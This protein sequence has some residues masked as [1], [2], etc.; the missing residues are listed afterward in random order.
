M[1]NK[2][3]PK[4]LSNVQLSRLQSQVTS[5]SHPFKDKIT[6]RDSG[7][8]LAFFKT[9]DCLSY[10]FFYLFYVC[11]QPLIGLYQIGHGLYRM[12]HSGMIA[13]YGFTDTLE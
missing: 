7:L 9:V 11:P 3:N 4:V 6:A 2:L 5:Q 1:L 13:L 10:L 8:L 12:H